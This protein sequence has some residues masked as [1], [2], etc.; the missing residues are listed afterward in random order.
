MRIAAIIMML[1]LSSCGRPTAD[2]MRDMRAADFGGGAI[3]AAPGI[4]YCFGISRGDAESELNALWR[5]YLNTIPLNSGYVNPTTGSEYT[6]KIGDLVYMSYT[7]NHR[8]QFLKDVDQ[9]KHEQCRKM[10]PDIAAK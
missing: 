10:F 9:S 7:S 5:Q 3:L 4:D 6:R 8:T 1:L 2:F